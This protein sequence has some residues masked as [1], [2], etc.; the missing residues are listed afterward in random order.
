MP[1]TNTIR[2]D[3]TAAKIGRSMK[4][5]GNFIRIRSSD[6]PKSPRWLSKFPR[7]LSVPRRPPVSTNPF[8]AADRAR[9]KASPLFA[10]VY[11]HPAAHPPPLGWFRLAWLPTVRGAT[12][13]APRSP[14]FHRLPDHLESH[15]I[16]RRLGPAESFAGRFCCS[17]RRRHTATLGRFRSPSREPAPLDRRRCRG[18]EYGQTCPAITNGLHWKR[19]IEHAYSRCRYRSDYRRNPYGHDVESP[20]HRPIPETPD[21]SRRVNFLV[22][23][24]EPSEC[25]STHPVR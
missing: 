9:A 18:C 12:A 2:N 14:A 22:H 17:R 23:P 20:L 6:R 5:C 25:T 3:S 21:S 7:R 16:H 10:A 19:R 8:V 11:F 1:P 4:K 15:A 13:A 24:S